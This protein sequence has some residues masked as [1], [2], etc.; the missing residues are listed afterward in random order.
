[1]AK[2]SIAD[3]TWSGAAVY[4]ELQASR[5]WK[6]AS[7]FCAVPRTTGWSGV[8][9]RAR[10]E[11]TRSSVM[12]FLRSESSSSSILATSW[13][14][15]KPS[16]KWRNGIRLLSEARWEMSAKSWASWTEPEASSPKPVWRTAITSEWSPKMESAWV[17]TARAETCITN[18]VSSPAILYM[19]G[20]ISSRPCEAVKVV[21]SAPPCSAP[22]T[23]PEAPP[24]DCSSTTVGTAPQMF[25]FPS[26]DHS[27]AHSPMFDEGVMG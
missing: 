6:K 12:S 19:L 3:C 1:L 16:K 27:S 26:A 8:S 10:W 14:V 20:I 13:E 22:C 18:E 23:A 7:G 15:R 2:S 4:Q 24:S 11:A 5:A 9:A 21:V 25:F 17:A